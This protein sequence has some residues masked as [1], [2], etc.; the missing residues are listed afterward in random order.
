M[1]PFTSTCTDTVF[2]YK[3]RLDMCVCCVVW[4]V[5][6]SEVALVRVV[7]VCLV[8]CSHSGLFVNVSGRVTASWLF[9]L[10]QTRTEFIPMKHI[11]SL[12]TA[13]VPQ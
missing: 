10:I 1:C 12:F 5:C 3:C 11:W 4:C 13:A 7:C 6:V 2:A 9:F 8:Q